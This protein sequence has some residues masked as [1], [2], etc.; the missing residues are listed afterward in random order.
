MKNGTL[1]T[2]TVAF[3]LVALL[4]LGGF[5][6]SKPRI[7]VL[8]SSDRTSTTVGKVDEGIRQV[9]DKN[10]QPM[11]THWHYLGIDNLP[12]EDHRQDA[13]KVGLRAIEQFNPDVVIAVDD[14]AQQYV[15]R[16]FAGRD[17]PKLVYTAIDHDPKEY[18][19]VG[20][21]NVTGVAERLPLATL[22]DVL[23]YVKQGQPVRLA[24]LGD[25]GP[26]SK[27]QLQQVQA[28]DWGPHSVVSAQT[29]GDFPAWQAAIKALEGKADVVLVL[30]H[31]S[32]PTAPG[33]R[34]TVPAADAIRWIETH[35][36]PLPIG[37]DIEFVQKGGGLGVAPS[38]KSMGEVVATD[39]LVW[40]KGKPSA[41]APL[42]SQDTRHS[43][44][45]RASSLQARG[46]SLPSIYAEA[47][48]LEQ[49]YYP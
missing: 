8:H 32:L 20:A 41:A 27:G 21:A 14:E 40:L 46:I 13:A 26:T 28:F 5:N 9:L 18:G 3:L 37:T 19:Y 4:L 24:V 17:R 33:A 29:L 49:L 16:R 15:V 7:L 48:R 45:L 38:A 1:A 34:T 2:L 30:S 43:M 10:R 31:G 42:A 12:D 39:A 35:S 23:Q 25:T 22:R 44:A 36:K 11:T 6:L 47:A